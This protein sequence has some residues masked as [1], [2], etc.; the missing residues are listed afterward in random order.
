MTAQG[1]FVTVPQSGAWRVSDLEVK[2]VYYDANG[3][4]IGCIND[5]LVS[6][7]GGINAVVVGV[8]GFL[9]IG[10]ENVAVDIG[11]LRLGSG[12]SVRKPEW[13]RARLASARSGN[14][15]ERPD[16][17]WAGRASRTAITPRSSG[18]WSGSSCRT[19]KSGSP[20]STRTNT[21]SAGRGWSRCFSD[22]LSF[23][24]CFRPNCVCSRDRLESLPKIDFPPARQMTRS[25]T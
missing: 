8:D 12:A 7:D 23:A 4:S 17:I 13:F 5:V 24:G 3:H 2:A 6:Q 25:K 19:G 16:C 10:Q 20:G 21:C 14:A 22:K 9:G 1:S 11:S 18:A 15:W